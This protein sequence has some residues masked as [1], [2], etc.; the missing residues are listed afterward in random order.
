M[1]KKGKGGMG[2]FARV[3][4]QRKA[5]SGVGRGDQTPAPDK[6]PVETVEAKQDAPKAATSAGSAM[7]GR[8][9]ESEADSRAKVVSVSLIDPDPKQPRLDFT[10]IEAKAASIKKYGL[11]QPITVRPHPDKPGR[12]MIIDGERRYRAYTQILIK[13][14]PLEYAE[15]RATVNA[16]LSDMGDL[17]I[18]Q[19]IANIQRQ[20]LNPIEE[21]NALQQIKTLKKIATNRALALEVGKSETRISRLLKLLK[22]APE[23]QAKVLRGEVS[24]RDVQNSKGIEAAREGKGAVKKDKARVAKV[25]VSMEAANDLVKILQTLASQHGLAEIPSGN[26]NKKALIAILESRAGEILKAL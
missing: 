12:F 19:L 10:E 1:K 15:I 13:E 5:D 22:L 20:D 17:R 8:M 25:P 23:E 11:L 14:D 24:A 6:A 18:V 21:A 2:N 7:V 16:T 4:Q 26:L 9:A 3:A